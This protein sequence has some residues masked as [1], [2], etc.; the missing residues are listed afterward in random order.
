MNDIVSCL[1]HTGIT[2]KNLEESIAFYSGIFGF[3]HVGGCD[4]TVDRDGGLK[5]VRINIAFLRVGEDTLELLEYQNPKAG[6]QLEQDPWQ[7][8]AQHVSF[9][10]TDIYGFYEK[11]KD[12]LQFMSPPIDYRSE[13][14]DTT[15]TYLKDPNGTLL[16]LSEDHGERKLEKPE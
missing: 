13:G 3:E 4:L 2:V 12:R 8:G 15:W 1:H 9:K 10:V 16:E 7:P 6:R 14:I 5:G 11:N